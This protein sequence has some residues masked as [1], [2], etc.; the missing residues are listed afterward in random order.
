MKSISV[1][2]TIWSLAALLVS[3]AVFIVV[4]N[5]VMGKSINDSITQFNRFFFHQ[6]VSVYRA[7][8]PAALARYTEELNR[9]GAVQYYLTDPQGRDL[10]TGEDRSEM[11]RDTIGQHRPFSRSHGGFTIGVASEDGRYAF[12]ASGKAP[13]SARFAAFYL[14]LLATVATLY[15]L[16]TANIAAPLRRLARVVDRFGRGELT[17]RADAKS[18]DEVGNLGRSFNAMAERIQTLRIAE[19]QLLQDVSHEL[20][21]PLARLTFEAEMV[22]KTSDRDAAATRLRHEIERLSELV[23][24][25]IDMARAE[26]E[27]G[28]VEMEDVVLN[29][30]LLSIAEDCDVEAADR[31]CTLS[32]TLT[33]A[34]NLRGD[35]EL[36]RRA[37]ENVIRNAI[38]Y[39]PSGTAV[40]VVL[41]REGEA[42][43]ISV[44][45]RGPGIPSE[46]TE[47][48]FDPFFRVDSSREENTGGL[49]LGLAIAR[50]AIRVHQGDVVAQNANPG[51]LLRITLPANP[52]RH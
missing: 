19:R 29:D 39:A 14:L 9:S 35:A 27:A 43:T 2:V 22:R 50:R 21:S 3:L 47:K 32:M 7:G 4:A 10:A 42:V 26:G 49:G 5:S 18:N 23:G 33:D 51:A 48:I 31:G 8:G 1:K 46:L 20:R 16:V 37:V 45:D 11:V 13:S 17:A 44:R 34:V 12:L 24:T 6:A 38:R 30:L 40:E 52:Q 15:W 41:E 28:A 25:L 36:L